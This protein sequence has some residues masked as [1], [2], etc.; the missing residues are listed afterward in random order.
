MFRNAR[1]VRVFGGTFTSY[2]NVYSTNGSE[3]DRLME[4]TSLGAL[5]NSGLRIDPPKCHPN[6]CTA[7]LQKLMDWFI[8]EVE[9][10]IFVLW[11]YG[12][13]GAGKS[14]ISQTFAEHCFATNGLLASFFFSESD[15]KR[16][17]EKAL[18]ATLAYQIWLRIPQS[19][20]IIEGTINNDPAIFQLN[21]ES[22]FRAL[23]LDPLLQL[24]QAGLFTSSTTLPYLFIID[25][26][27]ECK[28]LDSQI[29]ILN[30]ISDALHHHR[31]TLPFKFLV[32]SRPENHLSIP[33]SSASSLNNL[34]FRLSLDETYQ[35]YDDIKIYL[36]ESFQD[37]RKTHAMRAHLPDSW[38]SEEDIAKLVKTSSG[39]FIYAA[40]V[41]RYV[42]SAW[43]NP[44]D[45][46]TVIQ[47]LLPVNNAWL[48]H[49]LHRRLKH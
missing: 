29:T 33:F 37:I 4:V 36:T 35:A 41:V 8:G 46:L 28:G 6:T 18:V 20:P 1:N 34:T 32:S 31:S 2:F 47:G 16:N 48:Y 26:L 21:F 44:R 45:R 40:I 24:S 38:P 19:R 14:A 13:A 17:N 30:T 7:V 5:H 11:L 23:L 39:N 12:P 43:Y 25:G 15:P 9:W 42:S 10:D 27:D 3:M 49:L 22:Q